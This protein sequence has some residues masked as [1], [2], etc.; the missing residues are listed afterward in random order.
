MATRG[1]SR[2]AVLIIMGAMIVAPSG[3]IA[4]NESSASPD[5]FGAS[6]YSRVPD[7]RATE[8]CRTDAGESMGADQSVSVLQV[9]VARSSG[10]RE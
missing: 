9:S 6:N 7:D 5:G 1:M 2:L 4:E 10:T 8:T 3:T